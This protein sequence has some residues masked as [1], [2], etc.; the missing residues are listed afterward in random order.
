[1]ST[2]LAESEILPLAN[3]VGALGNR[4]NHSTRAAHNKI[5]KMMTIKF[6]IALRDPRIYRQGL[7]S[8]YHVFATIEECLAREIARKTKWSDILQKIWKPEIARKERCEADLL[9]F[10]DGHKEKFIEP[11]MS[12]QIKFVDHIRTV[13]AEKPY[14]L[15]AYMHVM[16][17]ALFAGGRV[18]RSSIV[19]AAGL[20]PR[21]DGH[22]HD[23]FLEL[24][25]NLFTFDVED[26][27]LLRL[28]YKRDYE[29]LTRNNLTEDE[30]LEIISESQLIFQRNADCISE[31]ERHN[32]EKFRG[33]ISYQLAKNSNYLL[34]IIVVLILVFY[35]RRYFK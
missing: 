21:K 24:G 14:L 11:I 2:K 32:L 16:Y 1:M 33:K 9:Y 26:E 30:K 28:I 4:I 22:S 34:I 8:Y 5:D 7:Q 3:D 31:I 6:A 25:G 17:L 35:G 29:I 23:N 27:Q 20:F 10:Y 18:F 13:T 19:K 15:L 12:E